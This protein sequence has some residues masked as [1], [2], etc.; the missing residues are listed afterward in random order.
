MVLHIGHGLVLVGIVLT[1]EIIAFV[2]FYRV[3]VKASL[4]QT[5]LKANHEKN[6]ACSN[7]SS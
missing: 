2:E 4:S 6:V 3:H 1:L 7:Q 5:G